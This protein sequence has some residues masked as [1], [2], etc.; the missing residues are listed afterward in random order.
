MKIL[1]IRLPQKYW[2]S[3]PVGNK[4]NAA[5]GF[6]K[7]CATRFNNIKEF[8]D[9]SNINVYCR[10]SSGAILAALFVSFLGNNKP[11]TIV[12]VKK[13]GEQSHA[14]ST[15]NNSSSYINIIIDDFIETGN[16]VNEIYK[17]VTNGKVDIFIIQSSNILNVMKMVNFIPDFVIT[18]N[19]QIK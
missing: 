7:L 15:P 14:Y 8:K 11:I 13:P 1:K 16:T 2:L 4:M 19:Y 6:T 10:G 5:I 9:I 12:H 17:C 3:Y 18:D